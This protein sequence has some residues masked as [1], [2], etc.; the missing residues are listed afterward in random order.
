MLEDEVSG[1]KGK[2]FDI[3][4]DREKRLLAM[5]DEA[6]ASHREKEKSLQA[7]ID[8]M[9]QAH[10]TTVQQLKNRYEELNR[11][12]DASIQIIVKNLTNPPEMVKN[13]VEV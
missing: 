4:Q 8:S 10:L 7:E 5:M 1:L 11:S 13:I 12:K 6:V 9:K 3:D 2:L